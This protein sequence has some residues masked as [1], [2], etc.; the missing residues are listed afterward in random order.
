[1]ARSWILDYDS[2]N[3]AIGAAVGIIGERWT[4]LV[5]REAFNGVRRFD[6]I[7]FRDELFQGVTTDPNFRLWLTITREVARHPLVRS[8]RVDGGLVSEAL[9]AFGG[10]MPAHTYVCGSN[11]FVDT[12]SRL[13]LDMGV[14]FASIK[15][16][17]YGGDPARETATPMPVAEG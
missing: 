3:C 10:A 1:M 16:E 15:T 12:A 11:A 4:F 17:R 6:D 9:A 2:A 13:L 5:L 7:I 8:G 14:P